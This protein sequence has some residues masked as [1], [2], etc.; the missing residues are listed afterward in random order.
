MAILVVKSLDD[1]KLEATFKRYAQDH[2]WIHDHYQELVKKYPEKYIAVLNEKVVYAFDNITD[3]VNK[4]SSDGG[5]PTDYA[6]EF[7]TFF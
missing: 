7:V 6:I 2:N 5:Y 4:I 3:I 1:K